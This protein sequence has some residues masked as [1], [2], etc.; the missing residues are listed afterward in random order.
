MRELTFRQFNFMAAEI[1]ALL[2]S[3]SD[4]S[5]RLPLS[6]CSEKDAD[7]D[8][9]PV[10]LDARAGNRRERE[11]LRRERKER[12]RKERK[13]KEREVEKKEKK[14]SFFG[15]PLSRCS[16]KDDDVDDDEC[17]VCLDTRGGNKR[18]KR[19]KE[20]KK[21]RKRLRKR[22]FFWASFVSLF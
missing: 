15:L 17:P 6:R 22:I 19:K 5:P 11:S 16:E 3:D 9:C 20:R 7:D 1:L 21:E 10:C 18:K 8:E 14:R 2:T 4:S 13:R 12:K